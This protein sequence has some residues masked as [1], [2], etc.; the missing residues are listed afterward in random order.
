[1]NLAL[2]TLWADPRPVVA[3]P[4]AGT[5]KHMSGTATLPDGANVRCASIVLDLDGE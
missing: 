1:M 2:E 3:D 4:R 5:S